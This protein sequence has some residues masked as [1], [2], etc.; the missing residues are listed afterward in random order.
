[1][2]YENNRNRDRGNGGQRNKMHY[3]PNLLGCINNAIE[4]HKIVSLEYEARDFEISKRDIEPMALIYKNRKRNLVAYCHLREDYRTF[5]LDRINL[6]KVNNADFIPR[7]G[8]DASIF[9]VDDE[10]QDWNKDS[11]GNS[12]NNQ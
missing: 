6:I 4:N 5:R 7:E 11:E 9:E 10:N 12:E 2:A 8:F 1:M 3:S